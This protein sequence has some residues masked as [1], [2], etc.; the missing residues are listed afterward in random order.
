MLRIVHEK[1]ERHEKIEGR[2]FQLTVCLFLIL[3]MGFLYPVFF[4][5]FVL[6]VD[7]A[8]LL[9]TFAASVC[10]PIYRYCNHILTLPSFQDDVAA[11]LGW[12]MRRSGSKQSNQGLELLQILAAC[13]TAVA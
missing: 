1:H 4:V 9:G 5:L 11:G 6:F 2:S 13:N 3:A 8:F 7:Y 10:K 12:N